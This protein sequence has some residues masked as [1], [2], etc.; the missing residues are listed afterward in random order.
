M[1]CVRFLYTHDSSFISGQSGL[2]VK[3]ALLHI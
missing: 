3:V 1:T 2:F